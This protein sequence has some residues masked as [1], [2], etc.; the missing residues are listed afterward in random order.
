M[1]RKA[2]L[3]LALMALLVGITPALAQEGTL[4]L[5]DADFALYTQ[6]NSYEFDT[7][8]FDY[9]FTMSVN[10]ETLQFTGSG[11]SGLGADGS[12]TAQVTLAGGGMADIEGTGTPQQVNA[13]MEFRLVGDTLYLLDRTS[14][15]GWSGIKLEDALGA[16]AGDMLPVD[17]MALAEGDMGAMGDLGGMFD[18]MSALMD[19][20]FIQLSRLAD[21]S[22]NGRSA[23]H[24]QMAFDFNT[25]LSSDF[26]KG[27][28]V[29]SGQLSGTAEEID[30]Q[31]QFFSMFLGS[32]LQGINLSFD[33]YIA[34]DSPR[35][36]RATL[37]FGI[38]V[39]AMTEEA[40]DMAIS[41]VLDVTMTAY[42]PAINVEAPADFTLIDPEALMKGM[43]MGGF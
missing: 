10:N 34:T 42:N 29:S 13:D 43:D 4:G 37:T 1:L 40:E 23:A 7:L 31:F 8:A 27:I 41:L 35:V 6:G 26:L 17:P 18:D 38:T 36:E 24:F 32:F 11:V 14:D 25:L 30:Q 19:S 15:Q 21:T 9:S 22:V 5:S 3:L 16:V 12:P 33:Q 2:V 39:P 20:G 28:L